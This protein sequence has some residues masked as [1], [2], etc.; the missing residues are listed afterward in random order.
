MF[1]SYRNQS[2]FYMMGTLVVKK[3][4]KYFWQIR[5]I[6]DVWQGLKYASAIETAGLKN[7]ANSTCDGNLFWIKFSSACSFRSLDCAILLRTAL[8]WNTV[9]KQSSQINVEVLLIVVA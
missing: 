2:G 6:I 4:E 1:P 5:S 9:D 7:I 3:V 8:L